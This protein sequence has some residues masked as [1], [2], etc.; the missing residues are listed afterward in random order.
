MSA[1]P[2]VHRRDLAAAFGAEF[3]LLGP[4]HATVHSVEPH[5]VEGVCYLVYPSSKFMA[6]VEASRDRKVLG[7]IAV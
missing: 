3:L 2:P 1:K 6:F 4:R 7:G 5:T